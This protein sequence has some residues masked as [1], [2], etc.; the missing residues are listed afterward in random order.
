MTPKSE[1]LAE[2]KTMLR[3]VFTARATGTPTP[4]LARTHGYIDGYMRGLL[5]CDAIDNRQLLA[6]VA[7]QRAIVFG[8]ATNVTFNGER[9]TAGMQA[10]AATQT[11]VAT[12]L[13]DAPTDG[14]AASEAAA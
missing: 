11:N 8:P 14:T 5:E 10:E 6:L 12:S 2:L 13:S 9:A 7:E 3:D 4:K 1:M